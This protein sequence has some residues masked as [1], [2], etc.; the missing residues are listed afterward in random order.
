MAGSPS[1][2]YGNS[3]ED[4]ENNRDFPSPSHLMCCPV[5]KK[6]GALRN[7]GNSEHSLLSK[8]QGAQCDELVDTLPPDP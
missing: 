5:I 4:L 1:R 6:M 3:G 7:L 8:G 2:V